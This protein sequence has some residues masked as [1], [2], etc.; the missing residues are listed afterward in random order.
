MRTEK[1]KILWR[2]C[3]VSIRNFYDMA[4]III[5]DDN[6][7]LTDDY[8]LRLKNTTIIKSDFTGA[9]E[10]LPFYYFL[11]YHWAERIIILHDSMFIKRLFTADELAGKIKFFWHFDRH[12]YNDNAKIDEV[13]Q[14]IPHSSEL[15]ALRKKTSEWNGCF[16]LAM[17]IDWSVIKEL[18]D[19]Y[20]IASLLVHHIKTRDDR[21]AYERIFALVVF[22][23]KLLTISNCSV[24]GPIHNYIGSWQADFEW[25]MANQHL[26]P[27]AI[28]KTWSGR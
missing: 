19:K 26:Y 22:K 14:F 9:A 27:Y 18:D 21:M 1:D 15:V 11:K 17:I 24:F 8:D 7:L 2:R 6:S 3:Y 23:E 10:V 16:G 4:K 12:E 25:Q 28:M 20:G 13:L 5:I